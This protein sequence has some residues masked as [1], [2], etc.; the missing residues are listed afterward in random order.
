MAWPLEGDLASGFRESFAPRPPGAVARRLEALVRLVLGSEAE[1]GTASPS[2]AFASAAFRSA[3]FLRLS[4]LAA[5]SASADGSTDAAFAG[6]ATVVGPSALLAPSDALCRSLAARTPEPGFRPPWARSCWTSIVQVV[7]PCL[8]A[9]SRNFR[10][11]F[12]NMYCASERPAWQEAPWSSRSR[13]R[14]RNQAS[15]NWAGTAMSSVRSWNSR[16]KQHQDGSSMVG[17]LRNVDVM[18]P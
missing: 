13:C 17:H 18:G 4:A 11:T 7:R 6:V 8:C 14:P 2:S 16:L 5:A 10:K 3:L 12:R 9:A 1:T 15:M